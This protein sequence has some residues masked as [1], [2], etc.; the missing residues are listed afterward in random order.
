V[1]LHSISLFYTILSFFFI[2]FSPSLF[3]H[4]FPTRRSS[5]LMLLL[6]EERRPQVINEYQARIYERITEFTSH[7]IRL[8]D[9]QLHKEIA[10]L[11]SEEHTFELQS[12]FDLVCRILL[13]KK[14]KYRLEKYNTI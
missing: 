3:L 12:R 7:L 9:H 6:I 8:D 5:D 1:L 14:N 10:L 13:E 11:R 2:P 4:S